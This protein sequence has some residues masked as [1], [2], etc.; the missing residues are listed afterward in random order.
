MLWSID[1]GL[2]CIC[3]SSGNYSSMPNKRN[4]RCWLP[5]NKLLGDWF[6]KQNV[7]YL[8]YIWLF[9]G[10]GDP[11]S[12][13][14]ILSNVWSSQRGSSSRWAGFETGQNWSGSNIYLSGTICFKLHPSQ[15]K[16]LQDHHNPLALIAKAEVLYSMC[17]FEH[18]LKF[19][20]RYL[21]ENALLLFV[22]FCLLCPVYLL[23]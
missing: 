21:K 4:H 15:K 6:T 18:A 11:C 19:F 9:P 8:F 13:L 23:P 14:S 20:S 16:T 17:N 5:L 2:T 12:D 3:Y 7:F 1:F 22:F 10:H